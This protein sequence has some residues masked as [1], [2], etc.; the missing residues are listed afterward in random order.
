MALMELYGLY[1]QCAG[2]HAELVR[3]VEG[4]VR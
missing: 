3:A 4:K 2:L 1:G